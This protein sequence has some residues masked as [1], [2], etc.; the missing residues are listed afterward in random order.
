MF[1]LLLS[2]F[3]PFQLICNW[4]SYLSHMRPVVVVVVVV[5]VQH[6]SLTTHTTL[7]FSVANQVPTLLPH[8]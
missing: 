3:V 4:F 8:I 2:T 5:G 1:V 7:P 6:H